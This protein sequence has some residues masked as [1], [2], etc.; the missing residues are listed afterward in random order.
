MG[1]VAMHPSWGQASGHDIGQ[2]YMSMLSHAIC[3][4]VP[5][6]LQLTFTPVSRDSVIFSRSFMVS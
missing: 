5:C 1:T 6:Y 4:A 3:T 2:Q